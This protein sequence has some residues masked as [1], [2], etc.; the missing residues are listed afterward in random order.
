[1]AAELTE[2]RQR[3]SPLQLLYNQR[4]QLPAMLSVALVARQSLPGGGSPSRATSGL[5]EV[6]GGRRSPREGGSPAQLASKE[7]GPAPREA[8]LEA[9]LGPR[10]SSRSL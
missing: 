6:T 9:Q 7:A 8:S 3:S 1:M 2:R 4:K 5:R 10:E